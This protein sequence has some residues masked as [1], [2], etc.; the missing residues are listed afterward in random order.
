[1]RAYN[2]ELAYALAAN[3]QLTEAIDLL[4]EQEFEP[5]EARLAL[6][7]CLRFLVGGR[8]DLD[9]LR[10]GLRNAAQIGF[11]NMLDRARTPLTL[12]CEAALAH[13]IETEFV[14]RL[15]STKQLRPP[16]HAGPH[17]PW[18]V[19]IRTLGG[20]RLEI[21]GQP[22]RPT[23][24]AQEKPLDLSKAA[25]YLRSIGARLG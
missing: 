1:M 10:S 9:L 18:A 16:P 13:D 11:I 15:I 2:V 20:F 5:R 24:K 22:Y 3:D 21:E 7:H 6:E 8:S 14:Q 23:H 12:L 19:K 17:W 25:R 4:S